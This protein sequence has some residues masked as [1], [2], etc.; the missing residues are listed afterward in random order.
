MLHFSQAHHA[1]I[2]RRWPALGLLL[3]L[4][5]S[6][7]TFAENVTYFR[8]DSGIA[9]SSVGHLPD[10]LEGAEVL[11]WRVPVD[12]GH[13]TPTLAGGKIFLTTYRPEERELAT[14]AFDQNTGELAWKRALVADQIEAFHRANGS[15]AAATPATDGERIYSFFGSYGLIC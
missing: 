9:D 5:A 1:C 7:P 10:Q 12:S 14:V 15:P 6:W 13:S 11:R 4:V 8:S 2:S 3:G